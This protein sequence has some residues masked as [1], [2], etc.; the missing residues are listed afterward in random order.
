MKL[1]AGSNPKFFSDA[2]IGHDRDFIWGW[3]GFT[4]MEDYEAWLIAEINSK[5]SPNDYLFSVGD[6]FFRG[7]DQR[8]EGF[9]DQLNVK[10]IFCIE[11]N[12]DGTMIRMANNHKAIENIGPLAEL[13]ITKDQYSRGE[14]KYHYVTLCH[15]AMETWNRSHVGSFHLC[16]HHHG[17]RP[18]LIPPN[19]DWRRAEVSI[20]T[21]KPFN[22]S[23]VISW[24]ELYEVLKDRP[25]ELKYGEHKL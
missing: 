18:H 12:H 17:T 25:Y 11:G 9:L 16:G 5:V 22:G 8:Y 13:K 1:P 24:S 7:S 23:A 4:C 15:Y 6:I 19:T 2:H 21:I 20:D 10:K 3:R 14:T